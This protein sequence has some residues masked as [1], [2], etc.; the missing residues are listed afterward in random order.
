MDDKLRQLQLNELE[1]LREFVRICEKHHLKY[2]LTGGTLLGAVRHGGFIPWDDDIDVAMPREDYDRFA[3]VCQPML[4][5]KYFYQSPETDPDYYLPYA[6]IRKNGTLAY[7]PRFQYAQFHKGVFIDIFPLDFCPAPG[8]V[9]HFL[10]NVLAVINYRG[11]VDSGEHYSPYK[12]LSGKIGYTVLRIFSKKQIVKLR[13][14]LIKLSRR[15]SNR[16]FVV[17]YAGAHGYYR[18]VMPKEWYWGKNKLEFEGQVFSVPANTR[19]V[20]ARLYGDG[21]MEI[22]KTSIETG[23]IE[24]AK[25][26]F[27]EVAFK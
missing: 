10:F 11:Q 15:L 18:E 2:V 13:G 4:A 19:G 12:E 26:F 8:V 9:C 1:I 23:H 22:P 21:Y 7:E 27:K 16:N 5:G 14:H 6:K 17:P 3:K 20:L 24:L 25:S